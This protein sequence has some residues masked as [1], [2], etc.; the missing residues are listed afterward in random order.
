MN[1]EEEFHT[2][3]SQEMTDPMQPPGVEQPGE[4]SAGLPSSLDARAEVHVEKSVADSDEDPIL[5]LAGEDVEGKEFDDA[6]EGLSA[7]RAEASQE[8]HAR[9]DEVGAE[10][11]LREQPTLTSSGM[12]GEAEH[13][14][15]IDDTLQLMLDLGQMEWKSPIHV[16]NDAS[17]AATPDAAAERHIVGAEGAPRIAAGTSTD[18]PD[19]GVASAEKVASAEEAAASSAETEVGEPDVSAASAGSAAGAS[20]FNTTSAGAACVQDTKVSAEAAAAA[21]MTDVPGASAGRPANSSKSAAL[22]GQAVLAPEATRFHERPDSSTRDAKRPRLVQEPLPPML[23]PTTAQGGGDDHELF[24]EAVAWLLQKLLLQ[25]NA[26]KAQQVPALLKKYEHHEK[27]LLKVA[28]EKYLAGRPEPGGKTL[29]AGERTKVLQELLAGLGRKLL[30]QPWKLRPPTSGEGYLPSFMSQFYELVSHARTKRV[31]GHTG[32]P[33]TQPRKPGAARDKIVLAAVG[34]DSRNTSSFSLQLSL[35]MAKQKA[36]GKGAVQS[37]PA[38]GPASAAT[39]ER[40]SAKLG[41]KVSQEPRILQLPQELQ[42]VEQQDWQK[43]RD[44]WA[45]KFRQL[46]R[47]S[48]QGALAPAVLPEPLEPEERLQNEE[49][50]PSMAFKDVVSFLERFE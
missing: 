17:C 5:K 45:Q 16:A 26:P 46:W 44:A 33:K 32:R 40:G 3:R 6:D 12:A 11:L 37:P 36:V 39:S 21:S 25:F 48:P 4:N 22:P 47:D 43:L 7:E 42:K 8:V 18:M 29:A 35:Q 20:G 41:A 23:T 38:L 28:L 1:S 13:A 14:E 15:R 49:I 10:K 50:R 9:T 30:A 24:R 2:A 31:Q 19:V 34:A 27:E